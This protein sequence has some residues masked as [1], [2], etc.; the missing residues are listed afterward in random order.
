MHVIW[1]ISNIMSHFFLFFLCK[2]FNVEKD[3]DAKHSSLILQDYSD[4]TCKKRLIKKVK[5][6]KYLNLIGPHN[7]A[8]QR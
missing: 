2:F 1:N 7:E 4:V 6:Y 3:R 5:I 8:Q